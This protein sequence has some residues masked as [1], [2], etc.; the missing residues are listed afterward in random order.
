MKKLL[1]VVNKYNTKE[2]KSFFKMT[3]KGKY[4]PLLEAEENQYYTIRLHTPKDEKGESESKKIPE[5]EGF[6]EV[7]YD[8][9]KDLWIDT[10]EDML[11]KY[12]LHV[13]SEKILFTEPLLKK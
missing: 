9:R 11:S 10:R 7:G 6:Y 3:I 13:R 5:K 12:I 1:V 4:I 2:G 8:S